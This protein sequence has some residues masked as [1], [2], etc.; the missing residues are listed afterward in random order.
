MTDISIE[1][2]YEQSNALNSDIIASQAET[3]RLLDITTALEEY[4]DNL[5]SDAASN[6]I[7]PNTFNLINHIAFAGTNALGEELLPSLETFKDNPNIAIEGIFDKI[8][9]L[10]E[11]VTNN[12]SEVGSKLL[13]KN[14][15]N[16]SFIKSTAA[17]LEE[18]VDEV[19]H[20]EYKKNFTLFS[21]KPLVSRNKPITTKEQL[22]SAMEHDTAFL[23]N[24]FEVTDKEVHNFDKMVRKTIVSLSGVNYMEQMVENYRVLHDFVNSTTH[25]ASFHQS[26]KSIAGNEFI[27]DTLIG[28][29]TIVI[30]APGSIITTD[31]TRGE[32]RERLSKFDISV[33]NNLEISGDKTITLQNFTVNDLIKFNKLAQDHIKMMS[34]FNDSLIKNIALIRSLFSIIDK[35]YY[36][37]LG[38]GSGLIMTDSFFNAFKGILI[39]AGRT[40]PGAVKRVLFTTSGGLVGGAVGYAIGSIRIWVLKQIT[41]WLSTTIKMQYVITDMLYKTSNII[42]DLNIETAQFNKNMIEQLTKKS[43]FE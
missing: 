2:Y 23:N 19:Q 25:K 28:G 33:V 1:A 11:V 31:S 8:K 15:L 41:G 36:T 24:L 21:Y 27:S 12:I 7:D 9:Q 17:R 6:D 37:G 10:S 22:F 16:A 20:K 43:N 14:N 29:K 5:D 34:R 13:A 30:N 3:K 40:A 38:A 42:S 35:G 39:S 4:I 32:I 26:G 18:K